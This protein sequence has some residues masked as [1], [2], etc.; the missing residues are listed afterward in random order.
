MDQILFPPHFEFAGSFNDDPAVTHQ[1]PD[2]TV[3]NLDA[4]LFQFLRHPRPAIAAKAEARLFLDVCQNN[5]VHALPAAGRTAAEGPQATRADIH[6]L[7]QPVDRESTLMFFDE[8]EPHGFWL[9]KNTVVG[10]TGQRNGCD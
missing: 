8:P 3:T 10:S 7:A 6:P 1:P 2:P 5:H 9:A 4:N